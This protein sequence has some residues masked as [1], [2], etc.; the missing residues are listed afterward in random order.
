MADDDSYEGP[1]GCYLTFESDSGGKL[2]LFY[3]KGEVP[4]NAV[5]FFTPGEGQEIQGFKFKQ[6]GGRSTLIAGIA[7]GDANRKKYFSGWVSFIK[8]AKAK[9]GRVIKFPNADQGVEV[10]V[11]GYSKEESQPYMLE[12]DDGLV[13][14][15]VFDAIAVL[16]KHAAF[17]QGVKSIALN[18][19]LQKA[20]IIGASST[21]A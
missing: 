8:L 18:T 15:D 20:S 1:E 2:C 6:N 11:I 5:G 13:E 19:F 10:D 21:L 14:V 9:N 17:L 12:L 4:E 7:G 16:P 3:S